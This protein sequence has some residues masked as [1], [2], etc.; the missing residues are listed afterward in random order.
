MCV[1]KRLAFTA[2]RNRDDTC[3][4]QLRY[5]VTLGSR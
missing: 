3:S 4:R 5:A 2:K 1:R